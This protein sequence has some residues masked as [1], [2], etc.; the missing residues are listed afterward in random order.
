[1]N[2]LKYVVINIICFLMMSCTQVIFGSDDQVIIDISA[3]TLSAQQDV[4]QREAQQAISVGRCQLSQEQNRRRGREQ[5]Q[6]L[7]SSSSSTGQSVVEQA[8]P[9][10]IKPR[11]DAFI[12]VEEAQ[13][14]PSS[15]SSREV[16]D[17]F[18]NETS[19][20]A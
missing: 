7:A 16:A 8:R 12:A 4:V 15:S 6:D 20:P 19:D 5:E 1:M 11:L 13:T 2:D 18:M 10:R 17:V 3:N 14:A 9:R